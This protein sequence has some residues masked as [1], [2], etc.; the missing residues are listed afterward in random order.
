MTSIVQVDKKFN[1]SLKNVKDSLKIKPYDSFS[2]KRVNPQTISLKKI[3]N[4]DPFIE[5]MNNPAQINKTK[6][7]D[8]DRLE[9]EQ[10]SA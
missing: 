2:V 6:K 3:G 9:E 1:I 5:A 8:L 7:F 10:W 4:E